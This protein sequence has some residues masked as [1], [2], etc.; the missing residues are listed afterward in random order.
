[1]APIGSRCLAMESLQVR[2]SGEGPGGPGGLEGASS[3]SF[4]GARSPRRSGQRAANDALRAV[5]LLSGYSF[6][7]SARPGQAH[8]L[9]RVPSSK[10]KNGTV[11]CSFRQKRQ[12]PSTGTLWG[13]THPPVAAGHPSAE[14][15]D[16]HGCH[17]ETSTCTAGSEERPWPWRPRWLG[18]EEGGLSQRTR[19]RVG[20][21]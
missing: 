12:V 10:K 1:M 4:A 6:A 21:L 15:R 3:R 9:L 17:S 16:A 13:P 11:G 2:R 5:L 8:P 14:P 18:E 19:E 7:T 20:T